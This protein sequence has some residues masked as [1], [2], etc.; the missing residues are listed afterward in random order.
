[1]KATRRQALTGQMAKC[2]SHSTF[3]V[4]NG[5]CPRPSSR[6]AAYACNS[7]RN[8]LFPTFFRVLTH[9]V[10]EKMFGN[11][12]GAATLNIFSR[13]FTGQ[14]CGTGCSALFVCSGCRLKVAIVVLGYFQAAGI[15]QNAP[16]APRPQ[17]HK[18]AGRFRNEHSDF[19]RPKL[20]PRIKSS[21][22]SNPFN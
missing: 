2:G 1:M 17:I 12:S 20:Q 21:T 8:F 15:V 9:A 18:S 14:S 10:R 4:L 16:A 19:G 13:T 7:N 6:A 11:K 22:S 3:R 5:A